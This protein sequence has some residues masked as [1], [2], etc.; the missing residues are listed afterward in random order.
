MILPD[1]PDQGKIILFHQNF[2]G[3]NK[4]PHNCF[5]GSPAPDG[6]LGKIYGFFWGEQKSD[7]NHDN[8]K[9]MGYTTRRT[10]F[11]PWLFNIHLF[12]LFNFVQFESIKKL[13]KIFFITDN[14]KK[15]SLF[16]GSFIPMTKCEFV[17]EL[18]N[19]SEKGFT[20]IQTPCAKIVVDRRKRGEYYIDSFFRD[21]SEKFNYKRTI[22]PTKDGKLLLKILFNGIDKTNTISG[23]NQ[24]PISTPFYSQNSSQLKYP[25]FSHGYIKI[26][27]IVL[28][29][30]ESSTV[31]LYEISQA[32]T[33]K[34]ITPIG[35]KNIQPCGFD[36][37][38]GYSTLNHGLGYMK[39]SG[40]RGT[41]WFDIL[42]LKDENYTVFLKSLIQNDSWEAGIHFS[43]SLTTL[44]FPEADKLISDEYNHLSSLLDTPLKSWCSLR[45][46]DTE[47]FANYIFDKYQMI[48]RNGETGVFS[49]PDVG[50]LEDAT[51]EWWNSAS[52]SG[53][54]YP[55]F[56]HQ[57]DSEPAIRYSISY[58]K[59]KTWVDN[60]KANG[61]SIVPFHEWWLINTNASTMLITNI[62]VE[63]QVLKFKIQ[64]NGERG[65]VNINI[66]AE[67][68][69][70]IID[71]HSREIINWTAHMDNSI[72]FSIRSNHEYEIISPSITPALALAGNYG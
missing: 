47:L 45:N 69:L 11:F 57:T 62:S 15:S 56:T 4:L 48:W 61:I 44:S 67:K 5:I 6:F 17:I 72:T 24:E 35:D 26:S 40:Y 51:W 12:S 46:G 37:P 19:T 63:D 39:K 49:E 7:L 54:T 22:V 32:A 58:S 10:N 53:M 34:F 30:H 25:S 68:E 18:E 59:F 14:P 8:K 28:P 31:Q 60:Y 55:A 36:G 13:F 65:L 29:N 21:I 2:A 50:N 1:N 70:T 71:L 42:Y 9:C 64:T 41:I 27:N 38:H 66:P 23:N 52:K 43:K 33:R 16:I 3:I 20:I